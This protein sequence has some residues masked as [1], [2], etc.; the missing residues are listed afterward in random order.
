MTEDL[1]A[2]ALLQAHLR[3]REGAD[4]LLVNTRLAPQRDYRRHLAATYGASWPE[5]KVLAEAESNVGG[6]FLM[7]VN[8]AAAARRA[9]YGNLAMNFITELHA[10]RPDGAL[11]RLEPYGPGVVTPP[12]LTAEEQAAQKAFW[13]QAGPFLG[14]V[15][16]ARTAGVPAGEVA[17]VFWSRHANTAG[18]YFQRAGQHE[19]AG[20]LFRAAV[21]LFPDNAAAGV[22]LAVNSA[23]QAGKPLTPDLAKPIA[24]F[25]L[26]MLLESFGPVDEPGVMRALGNGTLR[27]AEPLARAS[28]IA[29]SRLLEFEPNDLS[30][31]VGF[32]EAYLSAAE[33]VLA[34][35]TVAEARTLAATQSAEPDLLARLTRVEALARFARGERAEVE[36]LLLAAVRGQPADR[37][38]LGLLVDLYVDTGRPTEAIPHLE[39]RLRE[40]PDD[41][42]LL[43]RLGFVQLK[44]GLH[45]PAAATLTRVLRRRPDSPGIR[46]NRA[47]SYLQ[48]GKL[49]EAREDYEYMLRK[50]PDAGQPRLGLAELAELEGKTDEAVRQLESTLETVTPGS[51][52]HQAL[53]AKIARLKG[54]P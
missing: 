50:N 32:A 18:V 43:E 37:T 31:R 26:G 33:P 40:Q 49:K 47:T 1:L 13:E 42:Q 44:A 29:F 22:N 17:A 23:L 52:I 48:A 24:S 16:A 14:R 21:D 46:L 25:P 15:R 8:R 38:L 30:A 12:P 11:L 54:T 28:A 51:D 27:L 19:A 6:T 34:L 39:A 10:L 5:L 9:Y 53:T 20:S 3:R 45:E 4:H 35:K 7:L 36:E 41:D 2:H